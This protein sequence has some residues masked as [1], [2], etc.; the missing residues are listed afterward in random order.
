[1][2]EH[3]LEMT[4]LI[5][6]GKPMQTLVNEQYD[7]VFDV[8]NIHSLRQIMADLEAELLAEISERSE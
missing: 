8:K 4:S 5:A 3:P 6:R 1:M 7:S 2:L